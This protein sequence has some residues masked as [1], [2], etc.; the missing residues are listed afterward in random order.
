MEILHKQNELSKLIANHSGQNGVYESAI[1]ALFLI[2]HSKETHPVYRVYKP[3]FCFIAQGL[4]EILLAQERYEYG[5]ANYLVS[6]M[7]LPVIGQ[8]IKASADTPYLSLK[9][10]FTSDQIFEVLKES[11]A[12]ATMKEHP[13][14]ALYVGEIEA[15]ILDAVLRLVQLLDHPED[16]PFLS[17]IYKREIL[18]RL[19]QGPYGATL[20]QIAIEKSGTYRIRET[21]EQIIT[22]LDQTL[23]VDE[24][25]ALA[26]MS[27]PTF[28]RHFKELTAMSPI[29][30][31][32]HLRLQEAR[33]LLLSESA[34]ASDVA[35]RVG[36]ESASQFS[37]EYSRM[38]GA[39]PKADVKKFMEKYDQRLNAASLL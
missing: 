36:Y 39:P 24:L 30:F 37:R 10:E 35:F 18:Y 5:P 27:V 26:N 17:P 22:H 28:H 1:P 15:S 38:F 34:D 4:K 6:S 20:A 14:R 33:R 11:E 31:Q 19:L 2:H 13:K 8:V 25:A 9:L 16:I 32:K 12:I 3:S 7:N 21:I 23:R 29:Q